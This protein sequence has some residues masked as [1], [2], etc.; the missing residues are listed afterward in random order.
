MGNPDCLA[1]DMGPV[2]SP[3]AQHAIHS[4]IQALAAQGCS[5]YQVPLPH[6]PSGGTFVAPTLIEIPSLNVL[7]HEVFGPV[8]HVLR[9]PRHELHRLLE[10]IN[11]TGYGL[12]LGIQTRI[13]EVAADI[14]TRARRKFLY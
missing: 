11:A 14:A 12:T 8:L 10:A 5:V 13:D 9:Y 1:T 6:L 3:Q 4:H 7:E 2:I